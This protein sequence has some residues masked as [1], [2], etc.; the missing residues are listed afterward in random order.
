MTEPSN[1]LWTSGWD[2]TFRVCDLVLRQE[3]P[4]QPWYVADSGRRSTP[5]ELRTLDQIRRELIA[6]DAAVAGRLLP[7]RT[8]RIE[9]IPADEA[10][11]A[12]YKALA[13]K[14]HLGSQY[15]WLARLAKSQDVRLELSIHADDKAHG[16]LEG[17]TVTT[18][19][20]VHAL[21]DSAPADLGIFRWFTLP[22]FDL[23]KIDMQEQAEAGGFGDVMEMTWFCFMPLLD[24][25]PCGF[26]N[27]CKYTR[28][29][30]LGRRVP[31]QTRGRRLQYEAFYQVGRVRHAV[32]TKLSKVMPGQDS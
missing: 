8:V 31:D 2:S 25:K 30:G 1:V 26:C 12:A 23:S 9:D 4:V 13:A 14:S 5:K 19:D 20:G 27:P 32:R 16:F 28:E 3:R 21:A 15:D 10:I 22:L 6:K 11:S 29:E 7:L 18:S 17:H 24:G